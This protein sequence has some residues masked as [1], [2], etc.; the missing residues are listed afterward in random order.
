MQ[1]SPDSTPYKIISVIL[2]SGKGKRF[3]MP[4]SE[5][6]L[7]GVSFSETIRNTHRE[8]GLQDVILA[9]GLNTPDM[10][11]T[12]R[13]ALASYPS[14]WDACLVHP[15][16]H[17]FVRPQTIRLLCECSALYP[18]CVVR[19]LFQGRR[20]HPI[21]IPARLDLSA[22][23]HGQGLR[24]IIASSG[25]SHV[26]LKVDDPGILRNINYPNDLYET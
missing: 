24:G 13:E 25:L 14:T 15:V 26:D 3:G 1:P 22:D 19:P 6:M 23:H 2:A 7:S 17:P 12:L 20:G 21:L 11:S 9:V 5:A 18:E 8:A 16:D 10:I 4:K